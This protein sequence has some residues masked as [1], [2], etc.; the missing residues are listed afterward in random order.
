MNC[1]Q[2]NAP[3]EDRARFCPRCGTTLGATPPAA[4]PRSG[5]AP[6]VDQT[7]PAGQ[8][9]TPGM[10]PPGPAAQQQPASP[11]QEF[12]QQRSVSP[13][14]PPATFPQYQDNS[15]GER[16][17]PQNVAVHTQEQ[18]PNQGK[19]R[20]RRRGWALG[21]LSVLVLLVLLL[22]G[23]W[24]FIVRPY[25]HD[26]ALQQLDRA[27]SQSVNR[28]PDLSNTNDLTGIPGLPIGI[29]V[30]IP[31]QTISQDTLNNMVVLNLPQNG[32]VQNPNTQITLDK[33]RLSFSTYGFTS[34]ISTLPTVQNGKLVATNV[35]LEGPIALILSPDDIS[36][37]MD[38]YFAKAQKKL[39][40]QIKSITLNNGNLVLEIA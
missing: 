6:S 20:R 29:N 8:I 38:K 9:P 30:P 16:N 12:M 34:A 31:P 10:F 5:P 13:S 39:N 35:S 28:V 24:T 26:M 11:Y 21:C 4:W 23:A 40:R 36:T 2:C 3:L 15:A 22:A 25:V 27:M 37:L 1:R 14:G 17:M 7:V 19:P 18:A 32:P 33:V